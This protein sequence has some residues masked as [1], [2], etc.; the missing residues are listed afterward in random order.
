M[1]NKCCSFPFFLFLFCLPGRFFL[2]KTKNTQLTFYF[3]AHPV[4]S[5]GKKKPTEQHLFIKSLFSSPCL[6]WAQGSAN[7]FPQSVDQQGRWGSQERTGKRSALPECDGKPQYFWMSGMEH[8][9][10]F[11][12]YFPP[13]GGGCLPQGQP[14]S[15]ARSCLSRPPSER[16]FLGGNGASSLTVT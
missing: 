3:Q 7:W 9:S 1:S 2:K 6:F 10:D 15:P 13:W 11:L 16:G 5:Q 14:G 4:P 12:P 8:G